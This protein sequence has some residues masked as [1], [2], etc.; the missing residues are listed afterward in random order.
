MDGSVPQRSYFP[1]LDYAYELDVSAQM[2]LLPELTPLAEGLAEGYA[3][4]RENRSLI[5]RKPLIA[6]IDGTLLK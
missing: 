5:R 2:L 6:F 4:F 1:F 3:W